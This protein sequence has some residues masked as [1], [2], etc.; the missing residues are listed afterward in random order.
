MGTAAHTMNPTPEPTWFGQYV[1]ALDPKT[2]QTDY[3]K[4]TVFSIILVALSGL[5][6]VNLRRGVIGRR[7]LAIRSNERAAAAAGV[8]VAR[9]K[10][11]GFGVS[12]F[13]AGLAGVLIAYKM[14]MVTSEFFSPFVGLAMIAFVYLGGITTVWGAV[15]GGMLVG[16]G[17][18]SEFGSL[19]FEGI[20]QA[21]INAVGGVGLIVN[22]ILTSG[23]GISLTATNQA[24]ALVA[25][26]RG[27]APGVSEAEEP[28]S[29]HKEN[30]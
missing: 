15:L 23:E 11:L 16:G 10:M 4:Y 25:T 19:H 17:L 24:K 14:P 8:N 22:A 27:T 13:L 2:N 12:S 26:I 3:W 29:S 18:L 9:T 28:V 30:A 7:F 21:Y 6:V 5:F 20:T 1:G